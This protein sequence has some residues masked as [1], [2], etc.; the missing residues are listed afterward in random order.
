MI[1]IYSKYLSTLAINALF[2]GEGFF[3]HL[4]T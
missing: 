2:E 3:I 4:I 1:P